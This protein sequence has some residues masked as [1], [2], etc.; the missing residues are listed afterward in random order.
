MEGPSPYRGT[1][2]VLI[3]DGGRFSKLEGLEAGALLGFGFA[4]V[5]KQS[6]VEK[7]LICLAPAKSLTGKST[8]VAP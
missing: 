4:L 8:G 6:G 5:A 7:H 3:V 2:L 1:G